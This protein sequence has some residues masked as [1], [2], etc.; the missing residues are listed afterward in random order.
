MGM[1][2]AAALLAS[3]GCAAPALA[4]PITLTARSSAIYSN[5]QDTRATTGFGGTNRNVLIDDVIVP[6]SRNPRQRPLAIRSVTVLVSGTT[7]NDL[8]LWN[9]PVRPDGSPGP[10]GVLVG[11]V[12]VSFGSFFQRV[13]FGNG[14]TTL[15]GPE[16]I[17]FDGD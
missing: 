9:Y 16:E 8:S 1:L 14:A 4:D 3:L 11:T 13:T 6:E 10:G 12:P 7:P 2:K 5:T 17:A 15:F